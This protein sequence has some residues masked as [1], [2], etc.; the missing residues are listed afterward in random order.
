MQRHKYLRRI[1]ELREKDHRVF[2]QDETWCN[3]NHTR[4]FVWQMEDEE[5]SL[6]SDSQRKGGLK[7]PSGSGKRPIINN[8]GS[9]DGFLKDCGECFIGK[10]DTSD[11]HHEMNGPHFFEEWFEKKVLPALPD[12]SVI[13]MDNAKYHSR[14]TEESKRPTT[15]WRKTEIQD[16]LTKKSIEFEPRDT[17]PILLGKRDLVPNIK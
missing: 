6:I 4:E 9:S 10:K 3:A 2:Y 17:K 16:W 13:V 14:M 12:K 15:S 8:I 5:K 1:K 11:Y 7:V